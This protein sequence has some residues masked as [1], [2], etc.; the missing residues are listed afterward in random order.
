MKMVTAAAGV[1]VG[2]V[3]ETG[4][5]NRTG[6]ALLTDQSVFGSSTTASATPA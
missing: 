1:A 2:G 6:Q 5:V 3:V 4:F